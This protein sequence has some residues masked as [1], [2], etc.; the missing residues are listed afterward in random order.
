MPRRMPNPLN[1]VD[2]LKDNFMVTNI[3]ETYRKHK[4]RTAL[5]AEIKCK[6]CDFKMCPGCIGQHDSDLS[7]N[8]HDL[9][10]LCP[11]HGKGLLFFCSPCKEAVCSGCRI[12][13]HK[14]GDHHLIPIRQVVRALMSCIQ[15]SFTELEDANMPRVGEH[16]TKLSQLRDI[17]QQQSTS[18]EKQATVCTE[19]NIAKNREDIRDH[20]AKSQ[21]IQKKSAVSGSFPIEAST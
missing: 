10:G 13:D 17:V 5:L 8:A 20:Q 11:T 15:A 3:I 2:D 1:G 16:E 4:K 21:K 19:K 6:E 14:Q 9:Y 18:A 12:S 7:T